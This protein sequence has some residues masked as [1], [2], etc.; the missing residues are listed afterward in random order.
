MTVVSDFFTGIHSNDRR[1]KN[2]KSTNLEETEMNQDT[3]RKLLQIQLYL[4][5]H[6]ICDKEA[7]YKMEYMALLETILK[8]FK[9]KEKWKNSLLA[10]YRKKLVTDYG[11]RSCSLY[12]PL[13]RKIKGLT[14]VFPQLIG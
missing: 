14:R 10:L 1:E 7:S 3:I 13:L 11:I 6:P 9:K 4:N 5:I 2:E 8:E 12:S